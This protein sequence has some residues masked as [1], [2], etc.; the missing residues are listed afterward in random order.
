MPDGQRI[1]SGSQDKTVRVWLLNAH[2]R[3]TFQLHPDNVA[4][5]AACPTIRRALR[6]DRLSVKLFNVTDGTVLRT[7]QARTY[8]VSSDDVLPD[9]TAVAGS[10]RRH[11][12]RRMPTTA[13]LHKMVDASWERAID[14]D[15][16]RPSSS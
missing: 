7:L 15:M 4:P 14:R 16:A 12:R 10:L 3:Y 8:D 6:F 11:H 13:S 1:L 5:F 9:G 2:P